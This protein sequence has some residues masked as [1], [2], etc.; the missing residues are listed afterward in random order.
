MYVPCNLLVV[1]EFATQTSQS[2][3]IDVSGSPQILTS[4]TKGKIIVFTIGCVI[5]FPY[6]VHQHNGWVA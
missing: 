5:P 6:S 4:T 1:H 2:Y 3:R